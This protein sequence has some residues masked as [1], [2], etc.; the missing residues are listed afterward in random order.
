MAQAVK[1]LGDETDDQ[2]IRVRL[3]TVTNN[4]VRNI[5]PRHWVTDSRRFETPYLSLNVRLYFLDISNLE[6]GTQRLSR[7]YE[8]VRPVAMSVTRTDNIARTHTGSRLD[9]SSNY[10][11]ARFMFA[12][13]VFV[14]ELQDITFV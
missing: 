10:A 13:I 12:F 14:N 1:W 2:R 3:L 5:T 4:F 6:H 9:A 8:D 7:G 11:P